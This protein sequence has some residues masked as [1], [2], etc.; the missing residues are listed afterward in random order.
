MNDQLS[1][2]ITTISAGDGFSLFLDTD[3]RIYSCGNRLRTGNKE[4]A[5]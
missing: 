1:V 3:Q 2:C 5:H 4:D